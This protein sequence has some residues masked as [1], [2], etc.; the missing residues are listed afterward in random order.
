MFR[1]G[2]ALIPGLWLG[3]TWLW[4]QI[5]EAKAKAMREGL[6]WPGFGSSHGFVCNLAIFF[7]GLFENLHFL[8]KCF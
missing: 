5:Y 6:A 7:Q 2:L 8:Q 1:L 4:L 3:F